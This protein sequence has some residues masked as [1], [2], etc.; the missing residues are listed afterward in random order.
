MHRGGP[1]RGESGT[2]HRSINLQLRTR[3]T[4]ERAE[5]AWNQQSQRNLLDSR[6]V[7][8][9]AR[10]SVYPVKAARCYQLFEEYHSYCLFVR[11]SPMS[12]R[13]VLRPPWKQRVWDG[14]DRQGKGSEELQQTRRSTV[15]IWHKLRR[16]SRDNKLVS[17]L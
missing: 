1:N 16:H 15:A 13:F 7:P 17:Q 14:T 3:Q 6:M 4:R 8:L 2:K 12:P 11:F 5:E 9:R 10:Y